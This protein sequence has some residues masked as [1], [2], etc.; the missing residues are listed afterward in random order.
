MTNGTSE[1]WYSSSDDDFELDAGGPNEPPIIV[2]FVPGADGTLI[3]QYKGANGAYVTPTEATYT[4][5]TDGIYQFV[6]ANMP[7]CNITVT[8]EGQ[9]TVE[10]Y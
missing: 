6:R 7:A 10:G 3:F 2:K 8:G 4:I 9:F 5:S 1:S